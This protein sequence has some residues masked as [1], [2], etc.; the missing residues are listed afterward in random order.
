MVNWCGIIWD[1]GYAYSRFSLLFLKDSEIIYPTVIM[2]PSNEDIITN[3]TIIISAFSV[4]DP[5]H[6]HSNGSQDGFYGS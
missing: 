5:R 6:K 4:G 2:P 1:S 3:I